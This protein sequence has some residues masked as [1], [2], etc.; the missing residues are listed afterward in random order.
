MSVP[1]TIYE[2]AMH[3]E[4]YTRPRLQRHVIRILWMVPIYGIDAW[5]VLRF[6]SIREFLDPIR[7]IYE[8]FVIYNFFAYLMGR[9]QADKMDVSDGSCVI[10][11]IHLVSLEPALADGMKR[12]QTVTDVSGPVGAT[13][14]PSQLGVYT[15]STTLWTLSVGAHH[16]SQLVKRKFLEELHVS[17]NCHVGTEGAKAFASVL[18]PSY[19][20]LTSLSLSDCEIKDCAAFDIGRALKGNATLTV[21]DVS[22]NHLTQQGVAMFIETLKS[23]CA[24]RHLDLSFNWVG[25]RCMSTCLVELRRAVGCGDTKSILLKKARRGQPAASYEASMYCRIKTELSIDFRT[26]ECIKFGNW[27]VEATP[28]PVDSPGLLHAQGSRQVRPLSP[29]VS[30]TQPDPLLAHKMGVY[31][32]NTSVDMDGTDSPP[33]GTAT[34]RG[35]PWARGGL[36]G[37]GGLWTSPQRGASDAEPTI[38]PPGVK[39]EGEPSP[40][41]SDASGSSSGQG[42]SPRAN[43]ATQSHLA[44]VQSLAGETTAVDGVLAGDEGLFTT[45]ELQELPVSFPAATDDAPLQL[46]CSTPD[47]NPTLAPKYGIISPPHT[48]AS[49]VVHFQ[50]RLAHYQRTLSARVTPS[51][52]LIRCGTLTSPPHPH[53]H[54]QAFL[55]RVGSAVMAWDTGSGT[56][57]GGNPLSVALKAQARRLRASRWTTS[58][59][60]GH[61]GGFAWAEKNVRGRVSAPSSAWLAQEEGG[62]RGVRPQLCVFD[63]FRPVV[64]QQ[65]QGRSYNSAAVQDEQAEMHG[66]RGVGAQPVSRY[67]HTHPGMGAQPESRYTHTH[68]GMGVQD[69]ERQ[70][71]SYNGATVHEERRE[72]YTH[73]GMGVQYEQRHSY[74]GGGSTQYRQRHSNAGGGSTQYGQRHSDAGGGSTQYGQRHGHAGGGSARHRRQLSSGPHP[75]LAQSDVCTA[76]PQL[77]VVGDT[78]CTAP[79]QLLVVGDTVPTPLSDESRSV[80]GDTVPTPLSAKYSS[81]LGD[82]VPTHRFVESR[83]VVECKD[84]GA[85]NHPS[86]AAFITSRRQQGSTRASGGGGASHSSAALDAGRRRQGSTGASVVGCGASSGSTKSL[87]IAVEAGV[88]LHH[89]CSSGGTGVMDISWSQEEKDLGGGVGWQ[90]QGEDR[91]VDAGLGNRNTESFSVA[92]RAGEGLGGVDVWQGLD[93]GAGFFPRAGSQ[94]SRHQ[95]P[96]GVGAGVGSQNTESFSVAQSDTSPSG[97]HTPSFQ[98]GASKV[99]ADLE[100]EFESHSWLFMSASKAAPPIPSPTTGFSQPGTLIHQPAMHMS[101]PGRGMSQPGILSESNLGS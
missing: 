31:R 61:G 12:K 66:C 64:Q 2:V 86:A 4:Y 56:G 25:P 13:T 62:G 40:Q 57:G 19:K 8:A 75:W 90:E 44:A 38:N 68:P 16:L 65:Q 71:C 85:F 6:P 22:R 28:L 39:G 67:T 34:S 24:L 36:K 77:F 55:R 87:S 42:L 101:Q 58:M 96:P 60:L 10:R 54:P 46:P 91:R 95:G 45:Q 30:T 51:L 37:L 23:G 43:S 63:Q 18:T 100:A 26:I 27:D 99:E 20:V 1:I 79:P 98:A 7:E 49:P 70:R 94:T 80:V 21:L 73:P 29:C 72:R 47:P 93:S 84:L 48:P 82:T 74:A 5:F 50:G 92:V 69:D 17:G 89:Q 15:T 59:D 97:A 33:Q 41:G 3:I 9:L 88:G 78:D 35:S 53:A 52:D 32:G 14:P 11:N 83:S 76:P 81:V